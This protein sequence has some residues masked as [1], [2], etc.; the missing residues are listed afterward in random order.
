MSKIQIAVI[1]AILMGINGA[2][3]VLAGAYPNLAPI[4]S[5]VAIMSL[6]IANALRSVLEKKSGSAQESLKLPPEK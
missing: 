5:A 4:F 1:V 6:G 2:G 3:P